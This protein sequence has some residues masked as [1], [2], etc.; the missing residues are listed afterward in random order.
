MLMLATIITSARILKDELYSTIVFFSAK[1]KG[2]DNKE[3]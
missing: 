2:T 3:D 1:S